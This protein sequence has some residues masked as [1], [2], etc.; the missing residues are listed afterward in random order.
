MKPNMKAVFSVFMCFA[1]LFTVFPVSVQAGPTLTNNATGTFEGYDYEYWKDNGTG[2]M[3]LNGGG[4]FSCSWSNINNILFRTGKKLG[5]TK[6]WQD[7]G[8]IS[9]DYACNYQPNG[10]SYMAVYGWTEDPLVEYYIIDSYGTWKP[11]GNGIPMKGTITVDG[12]T[13][14]V[15]QNSRTGPSIKGN[16]T[17]QQ[18]W[19]ICTSKR[20]SGKISVSEHFKAWESKGMKMGRVYEVSM[21]V[22]GYQSSGRADMTKMNLVLGSQTN[23]PVNTQPP[24]YTQR[25]TPTQPGSSSTDQPLRVLAE[26]L[27][28]QG[29]EIYVGCAVP[30]NF[31]SSD[32]NIVKTEFDIVTCENNMKI[33]TISPSQGQYNYSGG[34]SLVNFAQANNMKVHGHAFVWHKYNPGWVDGTKTMMETYIN[35]VGTHYKGKIYAWDVVNEAIH[36]DGTYRINAIGSN[37]QDGAS[38]FGQ[39]QGK[40]YIADAFR[41]AR[42]ADPNAKLVY[43]DYDLIMRDAKFEG[44]FA[45]VKDLK[46]SGVPIDG[47]GF[48]VHLGP[49]F[50]EANAR[51]FAQKM[52]RLADIGIESYVTEMDVGCSDNSQAGLEKQAQVYGWIAKACVEQPYCRAFQVWGIR[53]SQS[54]RINPD[55]PEDRAIAPLIFND[56]GQ[57]KPAYYAI[58]KAFADALSST[59][60]TPT[61]RP[62]DPG[63]SIK[64]DFNNDG[65]VNMADVM[66]L[67]DAFNTAR[68]SARYNAVCDLNNDNA[69]NMTDVFVLAQNFNMSV[70]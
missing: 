57:K 46:S 43:N 40:Q 9:I 5:S 13:Y 27:R 61:P 58:Q 70:N 54:W 69:I 11:P 56:N 32:Q 15:Y 26:K 38:V 59:K 6:S 41:A 17:F 62:T 16:T 34:D 42:K 47:V 50:T 36:K 29:R 8:G 28:K 21:V 64:G 33:G 10:N 48:Q 31:S 12:R 51:N 67:A 37:G 1:V 19:S 23:P 66:I 60:S 39:K 3:T 53:D 20:T 25:P 35:N 52:Q 63:P 49:D 30:G 2:T 24:M 14:E 65:F 55:A 68:G 45:M 22:E 7:Y 44:V 4:T 18:Y